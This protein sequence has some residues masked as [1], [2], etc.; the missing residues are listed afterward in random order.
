MISSLSCRVEDSFRKRRQTKYR[1][2]SN[3]DICRKAVDHEFYKTGGLSAEFYGWTAK[4][5]NFGTAI[6]QVPQSPIIL[7]LEDTIQ[8][9]SD[10]LF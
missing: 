9:S 7:G 3:A 8:E 4:T 10:Y 1:H 5:A 6:R 2:D